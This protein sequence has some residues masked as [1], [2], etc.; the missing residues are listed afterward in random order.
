MERKYP[1]Q[2][3]IEA[4]PTEIRQ[5]IM[6]SFTD[7]A[8]VQKAAL[9]CSTLYYSFK[10][11]ESEILARVLSN[12]VG[13][14]V[15]PEATATLKSSHLRLSELEGFTSQYLRQRQPPPL[16]WTFADA[17]LISKIHDYVDFFT[18]DYV[19]KALSDRLYEP[20]AKATPTEINRIQRAF[21]RFQIY[22]NM[23]GPFQNTRNFRVEEQQPLF[24]THF[25]V[26][27]NEQL[28]CIHEYLIRVVIP[29]QS[30]PKIR[31]RDFA[32]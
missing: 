5:A 10:G 3:L 16:S 14:D 6:S 9:S 20:S 19:K 31:A 30:L 13:I 12:Q 4:L 15:L 1:A 21:Y 27:E 8:S 17:R 28:A 32:S 23:F 2:S 26:W 18:R 22:C 29:G 24:F 25:S 7:I 11:A